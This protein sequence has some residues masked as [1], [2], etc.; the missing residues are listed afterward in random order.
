MN[1]YNYKNL[2]TKIK[3]IFIL[4]KFL[5]LLYLINYFLLIIYKPLYLYP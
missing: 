2:L 1:Y 3:L 4:D 5:I